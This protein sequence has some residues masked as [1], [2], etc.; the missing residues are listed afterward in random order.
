MTK[1]G[2]LKTSSRPWWY[3]RSWPAPSRS[4]PAFQLTTS[5]SHQEEALAVALRRAGGVVSWVLP[6]DGKPT[7]ARQEFY[8]PEVAEVFRTSGGSGPLVGRRWPQFT[9]DGGGD[10]LVEKEAA[11]AFFPG[12]CPLPGLLAAR[13]IDSVVVCGVVTDVCVAGP[14]RDAFTLGLRVIVAADGTAAG[15]NEIHNAAPRTLYRSS[16]DVR[17]TAEILNLVRAGR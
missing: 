15:S 5:Q 6:G 17:P 9:V 3:V 8:G 16:G 11:S 14:A 10:L 2:S 4:R 7:S 12:L 13:G 1:T